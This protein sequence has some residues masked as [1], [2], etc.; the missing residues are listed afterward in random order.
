MKKSTLF[1]MICFILTVSI[2]TTRSSDILIIKN[3]I[4]TSSQ[5]L[6]SDAISFGHNVATAGENE[7]TYEM[8][9]GYDVVILACGKNPNPVTQANIRHS[10]YSYSLNGGKIL[11]EGGDVSYT[12]DVLP[13]NHGFAT[14]VLRVSEWIEHNGG[15]LNMNSSHSTTL[16]ATF[17]NMLPSNLAVSFNN[18]SDQDV[19]ENDLYSDRFYT[20]SSYGNHSGV[21]AYPDV[22]TPHIIFFT[23]SYT[24]VT[25]PVEGKNLL[26]N[27]LHRLGN[28]PIGIQTIN[29][30]VPESFNVYPNFPNPFNP[31]TR[32][33]F[34]LP[35]GSNVKV[36]VFDLTG[37]EIEGLSDEYLNSGTYEVTWNANKNASGIYIA[38]VQSENARG[39][40]KMS[41]VK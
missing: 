30:E 35:T 38:V 24:S 5:E 23:F 12:S 8:L 31:E 32:I 16:L 40:I 36:T 7:V 6:Y 15:G 21:I 11:I 22:N 13:Q 26:E 28:V 4:N 17:P 25:N 27:C 20:W 14:K 1:F 9:L 2:T 39:I 3:D 19:C 34:S 33:R 37:R 10:L 29:T 41:L 18:I